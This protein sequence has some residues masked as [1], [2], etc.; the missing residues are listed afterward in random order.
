MY[1]FHTT[2]WGKYNGA[3][4][5]VEEI[6][7]KSKN[8]NTLN[9]LKLLKLCRQLQQG[10]ICASRKDPRHAIAVQYSEPDSFVGRTALSLC[11]P[12]REEQCLT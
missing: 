2:L 8:L 7:I 10:F 1:F 5:L 9:R 6:I 3:L 12:M 4:P 11:R